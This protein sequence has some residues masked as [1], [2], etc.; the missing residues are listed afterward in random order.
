MPKAYDF[1]ENDF[2]NFKKKILAEGFRQIEPYEFYTELRIADV[3][4]HT[5]TLGREEGFI[6][7]ALGLEVR[8]WTSFVIAKGGVRKPDSGWVVI[9]E[10]GEAKYFAPQM[11]RTKNFFKRLF[12]WAVICSEHIKAR[13][14]CQEHTRYMSIAH[15]KQY[16]YYWKCGGGKHQENGGTFLFVRWDI[17]LSEE[18]LKFVKKK[19]ETR[20]KYNLKRKREG[21]KPF[22]EKRKN[23]K[24]WRKR[25][26]PTARAE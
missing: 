11:Y 26:P 3:E 1:T 5:P 23:R 20:R 9:R 21:K 19:R 17:G 25:N 10:H 16:Q 2:L 24:V 22:G 12:R 8:V 14:I 6:F 18:S 15:G 13:P 4:K 7:Y